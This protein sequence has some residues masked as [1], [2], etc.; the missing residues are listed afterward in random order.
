MSLEIIGSGFGR[1]GTMSTKLALEQLGFGPCHHM[2]EV[3]GNPSQPS[4][5]KAYAEGDEVDWADVFGGY[6]AQV[7][8]PGATVW[9]ELS[10][11]FPDAKVVHT[12]RS[13]DAWWAS[14][15]GTINKFWIH[16]TQLD[17]PPPIAAVFETMDRIVVQ[18][19]IGGTDQDSAIKAY[20]HNNEKVRD[21]IPADRL[22]VF[23][24]TDGWEPLCRFL[25]VDVPEGDFPRSHA[26]DEFWAHFGGEPTAA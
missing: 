16:R 8:F 4:Y 5:W 12:E 2:T 25:E 11:A 9:H 17:L 13:E 21:I 24:P 15:S 22:L 6:G 1:T 3:M 18:D 20:R 23:T 19:L 10:I 7:D 26:R 14:Y